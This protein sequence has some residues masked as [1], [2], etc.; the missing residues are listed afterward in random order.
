MARSNFPTAIDS[1]VEH[2]ELSTS[3]LTY[4]NRWKTL[5]AKANKTPDEIA[6]YNE[7]T[8]YLAD[9]LFSSEDLNKL[10]DCIVAL[11]TFFKNE[12][13]GYVDTMQTNTMTYVDNAKDEM[14]AFTE[15]RQQEVLDYYDEMLSRYVF[16]GEWDETTTY[17][18]YNTVSFDGNSFSCLKSCT[19]IAPNVDADTEYWV[20]IAAAGK[21]PTLIPHTF[22]VTLS[23]A[24]NTVSGLA[25]AG[26]DANTDAVLVYKD[27]Q[28]LVEGT[29]Y[30]IDDSANIVAVSGTWA[31]GSK[32][33][34]LLFETQ[35]DDNLIK[36]NTYLSLSNWTGVK[37]SQFYG[38]RYRYSN[39]KIT[40]DSVV[41]VVFT[42]DHLEEAM[43]C[44]VQSFTREYDGYAY[45]YAVKKPTSSLS[46]TI[47]IKGD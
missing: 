40:P 29:D 37:G 30:T 31:A 15:E 9:A 21:T 18:R 27:G 6:E 41:D 28:L 5:K 13:D 44:G 24:S 8:T 17:V 39:E 45:I 19:G 11:E 12:V 10:Q 38:Y 26:Y 32:F 34:V 22:A 42:D 1:F 2:R 36:I 33:A 16:L 25:E 43:A 23:A 20:K 47:I 3:D 4:V 35:V 14:T 7:L 46:V